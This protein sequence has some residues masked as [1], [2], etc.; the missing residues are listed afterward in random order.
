MK[1]IQSIENITIKVTKGELLEGKY[2]TFPALSAKLRDY[3][4]EHSM[5]YKQLRNRLYNSRACGKYNTKSIAGMVCFDTEEPM[6]I[7]EA[8]LVLSFEIGD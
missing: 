3:E 6:K 2:I 5:G 7:K 8:S 4:I 1:T